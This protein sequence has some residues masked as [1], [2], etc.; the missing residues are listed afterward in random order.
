M[1][2]RQAQTVWVCHLRLLGW[3]ELANNPQVSDSP[4]DLLQRLGLRKAPSEGHPS[5]IHGIFLLLA[6]AVLWHTYGRCDLV[7]M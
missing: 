2:R 7:S 6:A 5:K 3:G 4:A 1:R